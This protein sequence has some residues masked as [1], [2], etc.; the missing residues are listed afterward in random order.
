[1]KKIIALVFTAFLAIT[2]VSAQNYKW[3]GGFRI[4]GDL[5]GMTVKHKMN[6]QSAIEGIFSYPWKNG[7][8]VTGLYERHI[9]VI[10]QGFSFYYGAG[11]HLGSWDHDFAIGAD[12]IVGLEYKV[13]Q[14]PIA[15]SVDY[16]PTF[17]IASHTHFYMADIA[18]GIKYTF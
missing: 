12:A 6:S 14:A 8:T 15:F 17:N 9:P 7:F 10:S 13:S 11:A 5:V 3:A 2:A 1:M 4:G 18:F 16:K